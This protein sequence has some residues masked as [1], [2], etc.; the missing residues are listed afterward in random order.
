MPYVYNEQEHGPS[1]HTAAVRRLIRRQFAKRE[2][3]T[4]REVE[5]NSADDAASAQDTHWPTTQEDEE[6][7]F[8]ADGFYE[9]EDPFGTSQEEQRPSI[10]QSIEDIF[11]LHGANGMAGNADGLAAEPARAPSP[12]TSADGCSEQPAAL[13]WTPLQG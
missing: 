4:E 13:A 10:D 12:S 3:W 9:E 1:S 2:A 5:D 8:G 11:E 6:A 7:F